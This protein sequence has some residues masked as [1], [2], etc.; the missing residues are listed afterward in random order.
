MTPPRTVLLAV[1]CAAIPVLLWMALHRQRT[2]EEGLPPKTDCGSQDDAWA[3]AQAFQ[4]ENGGMLVSVRGTG[5]M[6]PYIPHAAAS[7]DAK[8][9]VVA[10]V[11]MAHGVRFAD[12]RAGDLCLYRPEQAPK[13]V[14]LHQAA[15]RDGYGWLMSG[16]ANK[17]SEWW[18]RVTPDNYLGAVAHT[19][20]WKQ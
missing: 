1:I 3:K 7:L 13:E 2:M 15:K 6:A 16:L 5:S 17:T 18:M 8:A 12:V 10:F 9:T 4:M 19:F 20:T 14:W 11:V